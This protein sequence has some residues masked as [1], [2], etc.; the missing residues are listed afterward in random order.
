M[1]TPAGYHLKKISSQRS[2]DTSFFIIRV[3]CCLFITMPS[4]AQYNALD[5]G[6]YVSD[7]STGFTYSDDELIDDIKVDNQNPENIYVVGRTRSSFGT[8]S[9]CTNKTINYGNGDVMVAK[10]NRCGV[11]Q[12]SKYLGNKK[13]TDY[14]YSL[15]LDYD[16]AGNTIVYV[17]GEM[18]TNSGAPKAIVCDFGLPPFRSRPV[19]TW[20]GFIAK[21]DQNGN[22]QRYT[23]FGG[24]D[25]LGEK[26]DQILGIAVNNHNVYVTGYTESPDLFKG[27]VNYDDTIFEGTGDGFL[28]QFSGDLSSLK[29]FTYI[30]GK[31]I[32]RCHGIKIYQSGLNPIDIFID[33]T[34]PSTDGIFAGTGFD[35]AL[36]GDLDGFVGKWEDDDGDGKFTKTWCTYIGG[37]GIERSRDLDVDN[38]GN[39]IILGQTT[40]HDLPWATGYDATYN[41]GED[42]FIL[43]IPNAGGSPMWGTFFGGYADEEAVGLTWKQGV[44]EDHVLIAGITYSSQKATCLPNPNPN[45]YP[46][47]P[48]LNPLLPVINGKTGN[49][50]CP[51]TQGDAF[52]AELT[53]KTV[54]QSLVLSTYLGG[55]GNEVNGENQ[56]SYNPSFAITPNGELYVAFNTKSKD[57]GTQ[58]GYRLQHLY[59]TYHGGIDAFIARMIDT[60]NATNYNCTILR[61]SEPETNVLDENQSISVYPNPSDQ[62][63]RLEIFAEAESNITYRVFDNIGRVV[64]VHSAQLPAGTT[65]SEIDL[66][67]HPDGLYILQVQYLDKTYQVKLMKQ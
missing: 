25:S 23:Y 26:V 57:I 38:N 60:S 61:M 8:S 43:K 64:L 33:G 52:V 67:Q 24:N 66:S 54:G 51:G 55:S 15:A 21:Y 3:V 46:V 30:G 31:G 37:P 17:A 49:N 14:G 1:K 27:A 45:N 50:Y 19:G 11:L 18:K 34:T 13:K 29:F 59:G 35:N 41:G 47:F 5:W 53:D 63:F 22:L 58:L 42:A 9:P 7:S 44:T 16:D 56:L 32:D 62:L 65:V 40:S 12:W 4:F 48:V 10:Y 36:S 6:T 2:W 28:A 20:D 39:I